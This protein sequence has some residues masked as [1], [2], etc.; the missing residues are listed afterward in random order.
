MVFCGCHYGTRCNF[1]VSTIHSRLF[2]FSLRLS[3]PLINIDKLIVLK[4]IREKIHSI[5]WLKG[6][7]KYLAADPCTQ[8]ARVHSTT[9]STTTNEGRI[10]SNAINSISNALEWKTICLHRL[11]SLS[12]PLNEATKIG[13]WFIAPIVQSR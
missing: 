7:H 8:Y 4:C 3:F 10:Q 9:D 2:S 5:Q 12:F 1:R 6:S 11:F 13:K